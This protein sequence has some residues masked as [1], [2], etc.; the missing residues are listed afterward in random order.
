MKSL[1]FVIFLFAQAVSANSQLRVGAANPESFTATIDN[2]NP[3]KLSVQKLT[4]GETQNLKFKNTIS[5][6]KKL[7]LSLRDK[8]NKTIELEVL[9]VVLTV[10]DKEQSVQAFIPV[11][12]EDVE[13]KGKLNPVCALRNE[14]DFSWDTDSDLEKRV[15]VVSEKN[16]E[17]FQIQIGRYKEGKTQFAW[18]DCFSF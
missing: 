8:K 6:I 16:Q 18:V 14:G 7:T 11:K 13:I 1:F 3:M 10:F 4:S 2:E 5:D 12:P 15:R 9:L 17:K